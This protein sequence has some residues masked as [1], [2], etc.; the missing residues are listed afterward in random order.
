MIQSDIPINYPVDTIPTV[1]GTVTSTPQLPLDFMSMVNIPY[2]LCTIVT[3]YFIIKSIDT[4]TKK[5]ITSYIKSGIVVLIGGIYAFIFSLKFNAD[6]STLLLS[7]VLSTF[8]YDLV[9]K[10]LLR[11][12]G[13]HYK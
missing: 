12:V 6:H 2:M 5:T 11:K 3:I 4:A 1:S 7:F 8:G 13:I 9:I 10:P